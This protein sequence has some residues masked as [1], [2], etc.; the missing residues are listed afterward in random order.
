MK[1]KDAVIFK[2]GDKKIFELYYV[3][4]NENEYFFINKDD[5]IDISQHILLWEKYGLT[6]SSLTPVKKKHNFKKIN[7]TTYEL[8]IENIKWGDL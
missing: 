5:I 7:E 2:K 1:L 8:D 6:A 4:E 3:T